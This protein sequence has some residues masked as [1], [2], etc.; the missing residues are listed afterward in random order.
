MDS[1][2]QPIMREVTD[3]RARSR[4]DLESKKTTIYSSIRDYN[5][6]RT[7]YIGIPVVSIYIVKLIIIKLFVVIAVDILSIRFHMTECVF[8]NGFQ[9]CIV[10]LCLTFC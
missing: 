7:L 1:R 4:E 3:A 8:R 6:S 2:L 9:L 10:R 5:Y